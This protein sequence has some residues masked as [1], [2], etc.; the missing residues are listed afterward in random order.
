VFERSGPKH[1]WQFIGGWLAVCL[2]LWLLFHKRMVANSEWRLSRRERED[3]QM[4]TA[5]DRDSSSSSSA[6][7]IVEEGSRRSPTIY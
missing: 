4:L 3:K 1:I 2:L 7:T 6:K 5:R